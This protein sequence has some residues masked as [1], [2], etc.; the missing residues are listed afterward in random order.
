MTAPRIST[1]KALDNPAAAAEFRAWRKA[2]KLSQARVAR[3][4]RKSRKTV[5][6]W[7]DGSTL[8]DGAA[9]AFILA[10]ARLSEEDQA[11]IAAILDGGERGP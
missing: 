5:I 9:Q 2:N 3:W 8:V 11:E 1:L 6:N 10:H 7:E 4:F